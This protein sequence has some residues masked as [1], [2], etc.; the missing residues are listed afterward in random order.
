M[1]SRSSLARCQRVGQ[2]AVGQNHEKFFSAIAANAI[3]YAELRPQP[4]ADFAERLIAKKMAERIIDVFEMVDVAENHS[5][6]LALPARSLQFPL[7]HGRESLRD[8]SSR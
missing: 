2:I 1:I 6:R 8:S 4:P 7:E 3:V 5:Y